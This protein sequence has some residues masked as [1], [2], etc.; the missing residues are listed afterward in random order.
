MLRSPGTA[1][2]PSLADSRLLRRV[3][4]L[5]RWRYPC[6]VV[7]AYGFSLQHLRGTGKDWHYFELGSELLFGQHHRYSPLAGGLHLYANY[8][9]LQIGPLSFLVATPFRILS[10]TDGRIAVALVCTA[11]APALIY[12]LE[13]AARTVWHQDGRKSEEL[14]G[15][16]VLLGGLVVVQSWS[17]LATV[18][19]HLDDV[20]VLSACTG[21]V[22]AVAR[23]RPWLVG[24]ALGLALAAKP[25]GIVALPLVLAL[26]GRDRWRAT[27]IAGAITAVAWLPFVVGDPATLGALRP[28]VLTQPAS[29]LHLFG[30]PLFDAPLW[31]RPVQLGAAVVVGMLAVARGRWGAVLLVGVAMRVALDP[32]VFLYYSAGLLLAALAWDLLRSPRPLPAWSLVGFVLL[33]DAPVVISSPSGLAVLRLAVTAAAVGLVVLVPGAKAEDAAGL[34]QPGRAAGPAEAGPAAECP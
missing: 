7:A 22:W 5:L 3:G 10:R 20:L 9:E 14:L 4:P 32:E 28:A 27:G 6:L 21:A 8:P 18:Y 24:T 23:R 17:F 13:Q 31:V 1:P 34:R 29:V 26:S 30:L 15:M 12:V 11:V 2:R 33:N 19:A 25:W 16:T